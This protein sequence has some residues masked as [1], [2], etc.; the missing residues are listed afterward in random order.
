MSVKLKRAYDPAEANDGQR[1]L[2]DRLWPR[3]LSKDKAQLDEWNKDV[4]PSPELRQWFNHKPERFSEF[5]QRYLLELSHNSAAKELAES[6]QKQTITLIYA[7]QD[8]K[9][10]HALVLKEFLEKQ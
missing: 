9:H 3:G 1:I 5:R 2:V 4:A 8:E 7:V 6:S 10:N